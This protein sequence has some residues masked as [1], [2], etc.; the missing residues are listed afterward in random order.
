MKHWLYAYRYLYGEPAQLGQLLVSH[1]DALLRPGAPTEPAADGSFTIPLK[2]EVL[3]REVDKEVR[4]H[5]GV[6][7]RFGA[8][9]RIPV[10]WEAEPFRYAFPVFDGAVEF[11]PLDQVTAQLA[12]VGSYEPPL[13]PAGALADTAGLHRIAERTA[14]RLV[15]HLAA[16]LSQTATGVEPAGGIAIAGLR[17]AEIMTSNVLVLDEEMPLRIA[18]L[19]LYYSHIGGAPVVASNGALVGVLSERDLL[20]KEAEARDGLGRAAREARRR[21][22]AHTVGE[23]CTRPART[24]SPDVSVRSAARAMADLSVGRLVVVDGARIAGIVTRHD[25]LRALNRSDAQLLAAAEA[26]A[27]QLDRSDPDVQIT[28]QVTWGEV[29][30]AGTVRLRS[31]CDELAARIARIDGVFSVDTDELRWKV[32]DTQPVMAPVRRS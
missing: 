27:A 12:I 3:G 10:T 9:I 14:E 8:R 2:A 26:L 16:K 17:V 31:E 28:A 19:L 5:V 30:L 1:V 18:A 20:E 23:A 24:T 21:R 32:D 11:E 29:I 15:E 6:A 25:V 22:M 7:A 13:G 4:V